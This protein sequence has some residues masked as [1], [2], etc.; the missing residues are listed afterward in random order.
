VGGR[1]GVPVYCP[2]STSIAIVLQGHVL[3]R[4]RAVTSILFRAATDQQVLRR[5]IL[6]ATC[7]IIPP[8]CRPLSAVQ[9]SPVD[10]DCIYADVESSFQRDASVCELQERAMKTS[11]RG[12]NCPDVCGFKT[13]WPGLSVA[14]QCPF[15]PGRGTILRR[16][17]RLKSAPAPAHE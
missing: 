8:F 13:A 10:A 14:L 4:Q 17:R 7:I 12:W 9:L 16:R 5:R 15:S 6:A 2:R 11:R 3:N 1:Y